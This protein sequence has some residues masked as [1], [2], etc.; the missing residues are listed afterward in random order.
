VGKIISLTGNH[1]GAGT[2]TSGINLAIGLARQGK[3]ILLIDT[4]PMGTMAAACA[5][6]TSAQQGLVQILRGQNQAHLINKT[7]LDLSLS[8][9]TNGVRYP[10]D[11]FFLEEQAKNGKLGLL[12]DNL[13]REYD[14]IIVDTPSNIEAITAIV[15]VHCQA[16]ILTLTCHAT[17]IKTLPV[18]LRLMA[19]IQGNFNTRL[20]I[21]GILASM[22]DYQNPYELDALAAVRVGFPAGIFFSTIIPR[23]RQFEKAAARSIP[24]HLF[25][26]KNG[27]S[28]LYRQLTEEFLQR[29]TPSMP[30]ETNHDQPER[31]F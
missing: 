8:V 26:E 14:F 29:I 6:P 23:S 28:S 20:N 18:L 17:A 13:S 9:L 16:V 31:L 10:S 15:L 19:K 3:R 4:D 2:T 5:L 22:V 21:V 27:I 12:L 7:G 1:G 24:L 30:Q 11:A 25:S